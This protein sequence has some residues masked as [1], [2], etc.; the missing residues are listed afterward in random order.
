MLAPLDLSGYRGRP[1]VVRLIG[2]WCPFCKAD[3]G[4]L[5]EQYRERFPGDLE[6]VLIAFESR[7]DNAE[8]TAAFRNWVANRLRVDSTRFRLFFVPADAQS[9]KSGFEQ[10]RDAATADGAAIAPNFLG[11]PYALVYDPQG[12]LR[13]RG[14]FTTDDASRAP[15]YQVV[16]RLVDRICD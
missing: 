2:T 3:I 15:H 16:R 11:V 1:V 9:G 10:L 13:L 14:T 7:R 12:T 5:Y 6:V 8:L 4:A